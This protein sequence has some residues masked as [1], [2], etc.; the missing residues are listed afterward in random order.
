MYILVQNVF[1]NSYTGTD[2]NFFIHMVCLIVNIP[3]KGYC[4]PR[5]SHCK[6]CKYLDDWGG[7]GGGFVL[8]V[9]LFV[10]VAALQLTFPHLL[11]LMSMKCQ[12]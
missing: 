2:F 11:L 10:Y 3:I 7:F 9:C 8:F 5:R 1:L 12:T 6:Y 4:E